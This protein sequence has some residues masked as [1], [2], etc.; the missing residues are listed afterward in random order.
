MFGDVGNFLYEEYFNEHLYGNLFF[1][2]KDHGLR[3]IGVISTGVYDA[4]TYKTNINGLEN[5]QN[6]IV[7]LK[8]KS[9]R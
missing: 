7:Y 9:K 3:I 2:D 5:Q 1:N 4:E 6:Q 8:D